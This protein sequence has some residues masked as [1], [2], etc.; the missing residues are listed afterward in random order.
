MWWGLN[1]FSKQE[2]MTRL[3]STYEEPEADSK[4][5]VLITM[6]KALGVTTG[7]LLILA[8][9]L[10]I[11]EP[12]GLGWTLATAGAGM[13]VGTAALLLTGQARRATR[14]HDALRQERRYV[15]RLTCSIFL[16]DVIPV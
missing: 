14:L 12:Q 7:Y 11:L 8:T 3:S 13:G 5:D 16:P 4:W 9:I 6:A 10:S 1:R 15:Q 2:E